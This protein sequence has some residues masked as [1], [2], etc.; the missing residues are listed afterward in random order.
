MH[1]WQIEA[2]MRL[3]FIAKGYQLLSNSFIIQKGKLIFPYGDLL[4]NSWF[5]IKRVIVAQAFIVQ[6][7]I[8]HLTTL[9]AE[10]FIVKQ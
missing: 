3:V 10:V 9:A 7:L 5:I 4:A 8:H 6:Q 2:H 1:L